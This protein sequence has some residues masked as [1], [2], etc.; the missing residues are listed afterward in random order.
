MRPHPRHAPLLAA[1]VIGCAALCWPAQAKV[2]QPRKQS[3][4]SQSATET[5][6]GQVAPPFV[7]DTCVNAPRFIDS[8]E[9]RGEVI[10]LKFWGI[11]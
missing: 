11:T 2:Q 7:A 3:Q 1:A 5:L 4:R 8:E 10:L 6:V 9:L